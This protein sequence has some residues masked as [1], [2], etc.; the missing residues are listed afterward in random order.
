ME[1]VGCEVD[2]AG[3]PLALDNGWFTLTFLYADVIVAAVKV[4]VIV[5][6]QYTQI[7]YL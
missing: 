4:L 7:T 6:G 1:I 5:V 2:E 3:I